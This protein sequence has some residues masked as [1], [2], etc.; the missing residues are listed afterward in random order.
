MA[1]RKP[2]GEDAADGHRDEV[3]DD[4]VAGTSLNEDELDADVADDTELDGEDEETVGRGGRRSTATKARPD[5]AASRKATRPAKSTK[6]KNADRR[7]IFARFANFVREVVAELRKVNWPT[8]KELL[9]YTG[10]VVVF[11]A[12]VLSIVGLL[13]FGF[14]KGVLWVFGNGSTAK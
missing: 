2:R 14:A 11:V 6:A 12:I 10:V 3:L 5:T 8:R 13:D 7:S 4:A 1:E 9:T